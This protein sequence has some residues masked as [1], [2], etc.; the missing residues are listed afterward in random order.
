MGKLFEMRNHE[1]CL[2]LCDGQEYK[3]V[4]SNILKLS[5][6]SDSTGNK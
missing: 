2:L 5:Y 1:V 6:F 4:A 3:T